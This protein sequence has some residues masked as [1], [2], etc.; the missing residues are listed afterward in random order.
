MIVTETA[1][2]T[3]IVGGSGNAVAVKK[4]D[5]IMVTEITA[6]MATAADMEITVVMAA[7]TTTMKYSVVTSRV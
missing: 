5:V 3:G 7:I 1:T 2:E 4:V 6:A